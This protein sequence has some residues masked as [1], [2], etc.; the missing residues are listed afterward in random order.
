MSDQPSAERL[1]GRA[2]EARRNDASVLR[3][4][5]EVFAES[6]YDAPMSRIAERAGIG[7]GGI[8]RR[9]A[10][11]D[12]LVHQLR[13]D[14][15]ESVLDR[16][17]AA[18]DSTD[19]DGVTA[20][21]LKRQVDDA[22]TPVPTALNSRMDLTDD[23]SELS[24]RLHAALDALLRTD[25]NRGLLPNGFSAGDLM[26]TLAHV[27]ATVSGDPRRDRAMNRR[28]L[29]YVLRG[30]R[31]AVDDPA[32]AGDDTTWADWMRLNSRSAH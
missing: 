22:A 24:D 8:Y 28:H 25:R 2:R 23:I 17:L 14:A 11:K 32:T 12:D 1:P 4:A 7:V 19:P 5:R 15:L 6:G 26:A 18:A 16:A 9:Y 10:N 3:A 31:S 21:F 27:R 30:L 13:V 20:A 29:D